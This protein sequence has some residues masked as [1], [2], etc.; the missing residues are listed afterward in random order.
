MVWAAA[1]PGHPGTPAACLWLRPPGHPHSL[2]SQAEWEHLLGTCSGFFFYGMESFLSH[3]LVE[4]LAAMNLPGETARQG[5]QKPD[6]LPGPQ[7]VRWIHTG[8]ERGPVSPS[9]I[10][11]LRK[12]LGGRGTLETQWGEAPSC[13]CPPPPFL[14]DPVQSYRP[15]RHGQRQELGWSPPRAGPA[16]SRKD[17][18]GISRTH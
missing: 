1:P 5:P 4:R 18:V 12:G 11:C 8:T 9:V 17:R 10:V 6:A 3:I 14:R 16:E 13:P 2:C 15:D 7:R